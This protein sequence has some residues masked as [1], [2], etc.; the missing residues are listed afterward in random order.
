MDND[1]QKWKKSLNKMSGYNAPDNKDLF[2]KIQ[3]ND[4]PK[5]TTDKDF[6]FNDTPTSKKTT[7]RISMVIFAIVVVLLL[8]SLF[9]IIH[10]ASNKEIIAE[11]KEIIALEPT[12]DDLME[13]TFESFC[14]D[15]H[16]VCDDFYDT[17]IAQRWN[18]NQKSYQMTLD[19]I[20]QLGETDFLNKQLTYLRLNQTEI[21]TEIIKNI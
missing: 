6:D 7:K 3:L 13:K 1:K 17:D 11:P 2:W 14:H 12:K 16:I 21:V 18:N 15:F 19:A 4:L 10:Q 20:A 5:Y 8:V 9:V